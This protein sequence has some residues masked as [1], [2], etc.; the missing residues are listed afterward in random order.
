M[1]VFST[2]YLDEL[3]IQAFSNPSR[4]QHRNVHEN[5]EAPCQRLFNAIE[6]GSYIRPHKHSSDPKDEMLIAIR[7][8]MALIIFDEIGTVTKV[9]KIGASMH[10]Q[11]VCAGVEIPS[12]VWHTVVSL[13]EGSILLEVK[14]GPFNPRKPK[15]L[16]PWAPDEGSES[17]RSYLSELIAI[18]GPGPINRLEVE[19]PS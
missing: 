15:D 3:S 18:L 7:G 2:R 6:P 1:K 9:L 10:N 16:A 5:Y 12:G 4:R 13:E 11:K 19:L 8:F 14:A 17:A